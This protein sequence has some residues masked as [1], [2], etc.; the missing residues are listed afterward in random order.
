MNDIIIEKAIL[1]ILDTSITTPVLADKLMAYSQQADEFLKIHIARAIEDAD[2][3]KGAFKSEGEDIKKLISNVEDA[4]FIQGSQQLAQQIFELAL[5]NP[6]I[7]A[8]DL[9]C[10]HFRYDNGLYFGL[11]KFNYKSSYIHQF[12][13]ADEFKETRI[14]KQNATIASENQKLE[15]FAFIR[16][17]DFSV[18]VKEKKVE[19]NGAKDYYLSSQLLKVDTDLSPKAKVNIVEKA[20][21]KVIKEFYGEDPLKVSQVKTELK[22]CV[23]E[24]SIIEID[25]ITNAVFDGN[26]SAQQRYR[27][28]VAQKGISGKAFEVTSEIEKKVARKQKIFTDSGIEISLPVD[29]LENK[30]KV[31]FIMNE[32]GTMSILIKAVVLR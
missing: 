7:P 8:A 25:R 23:D 6:G 20:A 5:S 13:M 29:Y 9:L 27:E 30:K 11:L 14:L 16:L 4:A 21:Q 31:E 24:S 22:S 17:D 28:E 1:H 32:D 12:N 2:I 3:K 26:F 15:E 18:L 10:C 19:I